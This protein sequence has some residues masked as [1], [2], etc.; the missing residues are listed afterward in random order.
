MAAMLRDASSER[1]ARSTKSKMYAKKMAMYVFWVAMSKRQ[2]VSTM[3]M[4]TS[5]SRPA[6]SRRLN[7]PSVSSRKMERSPYP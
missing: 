1:T 3:N 5:Y 2:Y 4:T 7:R 6:S